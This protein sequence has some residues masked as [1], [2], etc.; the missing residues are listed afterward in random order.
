MARYISSRRRRTQDG[1]NTT[2][3]WEND[4]ADASQLND[5]YAI[6]VFGDTLM[7][8]KIS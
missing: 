6:R 7:L 3:W 5:E 8:I 2:Q 4:F 1:I